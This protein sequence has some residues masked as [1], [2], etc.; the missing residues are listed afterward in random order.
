MISSV[1]IIK[2]RRNCSG[3]NTRNILVSCK[4]LFFFFHSPN[5]LE[6]FINIATYSLQGLSQDPYSLQIA[7][8]VFIPNCNIH[9]GF[10]KNTCFAIY[11]RNIMH[12]QCEL[13]I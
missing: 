7:E 1:I 12:L 2:F 11:I 8:H 3:H 10:Y 9:I 13:C 4:C 5:L 6:L